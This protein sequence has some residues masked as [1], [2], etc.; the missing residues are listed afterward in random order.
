MMLSNFLP[1]G[2]NGTFE[3]RAVATDVEGNEVTLGTKTITCDN[4]GAVKPFGAIDTPTQGGTASGA[5][6]RNQGWALTPLPNAIPSDGSTIKVYIDG[7]YVGNPVYNIY[8]SDVEALFP[9]YVNSSG[10]HA[11]FDFD[12]TAYDNGVHTI[13]WAVTDDAGNADGIG[14]RYFTVRNSQGERAASSF[15][16]SDG[17]RLFAAAA[18]AGIPVDYSRPIA[19]WKGYHRDGKPGTF[20]PDDEGEVHI[21]IKESERLEIRFDS[22]VT[23][24]MPLPVGS[25]LDSERGIFY[26]QPGA[27]FLGEYRFVFLVKAPDERMN[28]KPIN[29]VIGPKFE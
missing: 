19:V 29:V 21:D 28:T 25:T 12:T 6:F 18:P 23:P 11:Y 16:G 17:E 14:S 27:G 22:H 13:Q 9:G 2:G 15:N 3:L 10:A 7:A 24:V 8:R 20:Y 26:W 4:A 1:N 5:G